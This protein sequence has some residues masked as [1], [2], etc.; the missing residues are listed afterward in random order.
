MIDGHLQQTNLHYRTFD[1]HPGNEILI[2]PNNSTI[3]QNYG[4]G[5]LLL[6]KN[7]STVP[8][9]FN[10]HHILWNSFIFNHWSQMT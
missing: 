8:L 2:L 9:H 3:L 1:Y 5:P 7:I 4:S 6:H 10:V